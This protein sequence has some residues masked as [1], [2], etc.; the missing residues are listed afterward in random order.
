MLTNPTMV[1]ILPYIYMHQVITLLTLNLR[2][3]IC[4]LYL[5]KVGNKPANKNDKIEESNPKINIY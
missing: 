4:P 5:L 2:K 3:A 1:I